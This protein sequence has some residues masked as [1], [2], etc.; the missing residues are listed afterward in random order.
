MVHKLGQCKIVWILQWG[1]VSKFQGTPEKGVKGS[2]RKINKF[3]LF[4]GP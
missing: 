3:F 2:L 1:G 4:Q